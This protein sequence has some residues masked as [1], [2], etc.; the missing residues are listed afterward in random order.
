MAEITFKATKRLYDKQWRVLDKGGDLN[1]DGISS[2]TDVIHLSTNKP[3]RIII[4]CDKTGTY[5]LKFNS[6]DIISNEY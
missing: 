6:E 4:D 3:A 5:H 1:F 2:A